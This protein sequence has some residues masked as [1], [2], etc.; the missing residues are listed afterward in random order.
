MEQLT[1]ALNRIVQGE[2]EET[3]TV[4]KTATPELSGLGDVLPEHSE[5]WACGTEKIQRVCSLD[6]IP[7]PIWAIYERPN[8]DICK[9]ESEMSK[10]KFLQRFFLANLQDHHKLIIR[11]RDLGILGMIKLELHHPPWSKIINRLF[12]VSKDEG[13]QRL[14]IDA[15]KANTIFE[16]PPEAYLPNPGCVADSVL[17]SQHPLYETM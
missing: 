7:I 8:E 6:N 2:L 14:I 11:L 1:I 9:S 15:R 5:K 4:G 10:T 16:N 12:I 13:N 17:E 3:S